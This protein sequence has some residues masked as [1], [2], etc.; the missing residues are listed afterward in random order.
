MFSF[1]WW[2][3]LSIGFLSL[4][5]EILWVRAA[6]FAFETLPFAF[7]FVLACYLV[8]IAFGA[9]YGKRLCARVTNLY[10]AAALVLAA[11][12]VADAAVPALI[13][14]V[15]HQDFP[16]KFPLF[17]VLISVTAGLK[18]VLF[19]IAHHLGS[20]AQGA[21]VGRSVSRIYF[22]NII[23]ATLGPLVTGFI[24]LDRLS[25]DECFALAAAACLLL[26]MLCVLHSRA[27]Q[28]LAAPAIAAALLS[29]FSARI[30]QPG[31]GA[32]RVVAVG[33]QHMTHWAANRHG[34]VHTVKVNVG[35]YVFGGN[36][37]DGI[38]TVDVNVNANR[39]DRLYLL[40]LLHR[41]PK[42]VLSIGMSTGAWIR[43]V[44]GFAGVETID[45]VEINP[46]YVQLTRQYAD[47]APLLD[48]PRVHIHIDD[49]RRWLRRNP[50]ARY[51]LV[52]Q[53]TTYHW[54]ANADNL[55]SQEYLQNVRT[56]MNPGAVLTTNATGS[57]DVLA[58]MAAVFPFAYRYANFGYASDHALTPDLS[59]LLSLRRPDGEPFS[60]TNVPMASVV[61]L[62][63]VAKLQEA[64]PFIASR[65]AVARIITDDNLLTEYRHGRRIGP[66]WLQALQPPTAPEF[67]LDD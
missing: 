11:A 2:L 66:E 13:G 41:Q 36:V 19:P 28:L 21:R 52:I 56:H 45:V 62:L 54:R 15:L 17:A 51:D 7:A 53:N 39:L 33:N 63:S 46:A 57:F 38:A 58:T 6:G 4:S 16:Y 64:G 48:D 47:L 55:L 67:G 40:A 29:T 24:A 30:V 37:Y 65:N 23:G 49:G 60:L 20:V 35:D 50:E 18:S 14:G 10:G 34:I 22:G 25:V 9:A 42:R 8:G 59:L 26:S 1:P 27:W 31:P 32:L 44:Q 5:E 3:S 43:A 12:S 61:G